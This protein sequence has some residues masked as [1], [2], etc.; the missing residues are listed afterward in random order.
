M[1]KVFF[2]NE[3][4]MSQDFM[5]YLSKF[6]VKRGE[7][8][9]HTS[10]GRVKATY[11][12]DDNNQSIFLQKYSSVIAEGDVLCITEKPG[13]Y[14][15]LRID[16]DMKSS[17][18]DGCKRMYTLE[19][20]KMI[21]RWV[22]NILRNSIDEDILEDK[23]L[24]CILLEKPAP[25]SDTGVI[26]DGFHLH[27]PH[28]ICEGW[29]QDDFIRNQLNEKIKEGFVFKNSNYITPLTDLIDKNIAGKVWLMYGSAKND[30][31]GTQP[32]LATHFYKEDTEECD[33]EYIFK[34]ELIGRH[35]SAKFY[36]PTFLS[37]RDWETCTVLKDS[38]ASQ[39]YNK[40]TK[41]KK[42]IIA[43]KRDDT[44]I[45]EDLKTI[46]DG[47]IMD[48]ISLNR[49]EN[50][51]HWIDVGWT[52][53][54]IGEG[55]EDALN[56]WIDFSRKS[57]K[58]VSGE[59]EEAWSKMEL[60]GKTIASLLAMAKVD[61]PN[62]Y[63][64]WKST[65]INYHLNN[66]LQTDKPNEH[67][68]STIVHHLYKDK[69]VCAD[70]KKDIW[71]E[72]KQHRW[73]ILDDGISL[74]KLFCNEIRMF[75]YAYKEDIVHRQRETQDDN[76]K[77]R[78][79]VQELR[80]L[81]MTTALKEVA[82]HEKVMKMCKIFFHD[83]TFLKLMDENRLLFG[84]NNGV[85]DL[86]MKIFR[87]GRPDDY[88]TLSSN[89]D[90]NPYYSNDDDEI[91]EVY[92]FIQKIFPDEPLR[93]Y[94]LDAICGCLEGGNTSKIFIVHTGPPDGG[95]SLTM[96]FV[97][98]TFGEYCIKFPRELFIAGGKNSSSGARPE[99]ARTRGRRL[100][101]GQEVT[102]QEKFNN[103]VIKELTGN[104]TFFTRN[105]FEKG[106][107]I[108]PQ[109][110]L[111]M[112]CNK[113]PAVPG[114]D[115]AVWARTRLLP[116]KSKFVK[117]RE[118]DKF[119]VPETEEERIALKRWKADPSLGDRL[120]ELTS[121]FLWILF[122]RYADY[123]ARGLRDPVEVQSVTQA[124]RSENDIFM[125]YKK[126]RIVYEAGEFLRLTDVVND[127]N[128]WFRESFGL[129]EKKS[130]LVISTE[131]SRKLETPIAKKGTSNGWHNFKI[132]TEDLKDEDAAALK[133]AL[134]K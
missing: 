58:F 134:V 86:G 9:T 48:M 132:M 83:A 31:E 122:T 94:F 36:L 102:D 69:F 10:M 40:T 79:E 13:A 92:N 108:K 15:P 115:D 98:K 7:L 126:D 84:C 109:F 105:L 16:F 100:G 24:Y 33:C 20:V 125:Q 70:A 11:Y 71:Y 18:D 75:F 101:L 45:Y 63:N 88:I 99:M 89:V 43:R 95:K 46:T 54:N 81:K 37:V 23:Y 30:N 121:A 117:A 32:Y 51:D 41:R 107:E 76:E 52:L 74:K 12:V 8:H 2:K 133:T 26:K 91:H 21:I 118:L 22:Q 66:A 103:G 113:P 73:H 104:D 72:F 53:Y 119:P 44:A 78:L 110:T 34:E 129:R 59:C 56:L 47:N 106:A 111:M 87:E 38:V 127:F 17:I 93:E 35:H 77:A 62:E 112:Q 1:K 85:L 96:S 116:Y 28:F 4:E 61:S 60:K 131:L 67:D 80:C 82:F 50:Y 64:L 65:Q 120:E 114:D 97:E 130:R 5:Y 14:A 128:D 68:V 57:S 42:K 29:F 3:K 39:K 19:D 27:F 90:Y 25:R 6:S 123:K 49:A 124:Y 55:C